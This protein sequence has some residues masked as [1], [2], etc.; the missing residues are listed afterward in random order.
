M[1]AWTKSPDAAGVREPGVRRDYDAQ[2]RLV[3]R[4]RRTACLAA[5]LLLPRH[6]LPHVVA[7]TALMHHGDNL[8]DTGPRREAAWAAWER[9]VREALR[10][11][12]SEDPLLRA[13]LHTPSARPRLHGTA[14][15]YP[16][17]A[18]AELDF[19]G[20]ATEADYQACPDASCLP[21]SCWSPICSG[22][23]RKRRPGPT[24]PRPGL[25]TPGRRR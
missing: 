2:R 18:A 14:E 16:S 21:P 3:R 23:G 12:T 24:G 20:F 15:R 19:A 25:H 17:T 9:Q 11:G 6:L 13:C 8:L 5:R 1:S 10:A 22:P 4:H 7:A